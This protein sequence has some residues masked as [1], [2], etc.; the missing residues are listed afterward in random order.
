MFWKSPTISLHA[1]KVKKKNILIFL[2]YTL[3]PGLAIKTCQL[4]V[5]FSSCV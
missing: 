5:E 4:Q 1:F 3:R 2:S